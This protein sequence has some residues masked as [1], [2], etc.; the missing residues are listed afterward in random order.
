[1]GTWRKWVPG[2]VGRLG[3]TTSATRDGSVGG[4]PPVR[5]LDRFPCTRHLRTVS[6]LGIG[7]KSGGQ[8]FWLDSSRDRGWLAVGIVAVLLATLFNPLGFAEEPVVGGQARIS[9]ANGDDVRLRDE[10]RYNGTLIRFL[11]EGTVLDVVD[12]PS[13]RGRQHVSINFP[14]MAT[15]AISFPTISPSTMAP[16]RLPAIR[17]V[18][19]LAPP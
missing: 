6:R 3:C 12:G 5:R 1:M 7:G 19:S 9:Y 11:P 17:R 18:R 14:S 4:L 15:L 2:K 13:R 16:L 8:G 10:P